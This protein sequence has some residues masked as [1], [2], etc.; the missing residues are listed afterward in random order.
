MPRFCGHDRAMRLAAALMRIPDRERAHTGIAA[1]RE[2]MS[3]IVAL[4]WPLVV[5]NVLNVGLQVVNTVMAGRLDAAT[6]A[7]IAVGGAIY[8]PLFLF[9]LGVLLSISVFAAQHT[10]A[11]RPA[12]VGETARQGVWLALLVAGLMIIVMRSVRPIIALLGLEPEVTE[13]AVGYL[14]A[15]SW[16]MLGI[17]PFLVMRLTSEGLGYTRPIM[18]FSMTALLVNAL[19]NWLFMY[20]NAG[21]PRMGAVGCGWSSAL[22]MWVVL[23]AMVS[24]IRRAPRYRPIGLFDRFAL[25]HPRLLRDLL[26]VGLPIASAMVLET[27]LFGIVTLFMGLLGTRV[28]AAH[29]IAFNVT[30]LLFMIPLG[31]S[32]AITV[33]VGHAI[34]RGNPAAALH[35]GRCGALICA[36][37]GMLTGMLTALGA[38]RI[39]AVYTADAG[40][41]SI[42][43]QLIFISAVFQV[44]DA[45]QIAAIGGLRGVRD[46]RVAMFTNLVAFWGIGCPLAYALGIQLGIGAFGVWTGLIVSIAI[47]AVAHPLRLHLVMTRLRADGARLAPGG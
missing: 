39:A 36:G 29:Q 1:V 4:G 18:F 28:V 23:L 14:K 12:E 35:T 5:S 46:T 17:Y 27:S 24:F 37:V 41:A 10:G 33:R 8:A 42:A 20:G 25:P 43:V 40:V 44:F 22:A 9:G 26:K 6:L 32:Y 47:V 2:E 13:L 11:E 15:M 16:G 38:V 19:G 45:I 34:G 21:F 3:A 31:L 7:A 30:A